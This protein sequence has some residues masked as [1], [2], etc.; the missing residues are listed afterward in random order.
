MLLRVP[1]GKFEDNMKSPDLVQPTIVIEECDDIVEEVNQQDIKS[2]EHTHLLPIDKARRRVR[3]KYSESTG[4]LTFNP[5][6]D[7]GSIYT[8]P[9]MFSLISMPIELEYSKGNYNTVTCLMIFL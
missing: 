8:A 5:V 7:G 6:S 3:S 9:S 2:P 1:P 4:D